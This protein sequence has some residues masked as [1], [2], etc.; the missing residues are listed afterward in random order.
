[1]IVSSEGVVL[2]LTFKHVVLSGQD[3]IVQPSQVDKS[4]EHGRVASFHE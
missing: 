3:S 4:S 1:M 2:R